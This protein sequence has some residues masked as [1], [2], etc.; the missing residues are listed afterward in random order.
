MK[1]LIGI[2][3]FIGCYTNIAAQEY[4][5]YRERFD[6]GYCTATAICIQDTSFYTF[7][8]I[9]DTISPYN[10]GLILLQYDFD[11]ILKNLQYAHDESSRTFFSANPVMLT[12]SF[13]IVNGQIK[14]D[15]LDR[16]PL[17]LKI[18]LNGNVIW[19]KFYEHFTDRDYI[20]NRAM[21]YH[22]NQK[23]Y[24][25]NRLRYDGEQENMSVQVI[26]TSGNLIHN[27]FI[28]LDDWG[29][30]QCIQSW[31]NQLVLGGMRNIGTP[32]DIGH[33]T[34]YL[35]VGI[36]EEGNKLWE[37]T[38]SNP[39]NTLG[40]FDL[41]LSGNNNLVGVAAEGI[42]IIVNPTTSTIQNTKHIIFE[43][44]Q[45][46][47]IIWETKFSESSTPTGHNYFRTLHKCQDNSGYIAGGTIYATGPN[48]TGE[49]LGYL[50]KVSNSGDSLWTRKVLHYVDEGELDSLS[51]YTH[52]IYDI[53]ETPN[54]DI[55]I[56]GEA[57]ENDFYPQQAWIAQVDEYGCHVSGCHIL[58]ATRDLS[59][60]DFLWLIHP[61]PASS[62]VSIYLSEFDFEE[63][64]KLM[65]YSIDG[66]LLKVVDANFG[67]TTYNLPLQN[68]PNGQ[69][70]LCWKIDNSIEKS[71]QLLIQK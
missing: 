24:L 30:V 45:N 15:S 49:V 32:E 10:S 16:L 17:L 71:E 38:S 34:E 8:L 11:G 62:H 63:S 37:W 44:D 66:R 47:E 9:A 35:L 5:N 43:L 50:A 1:T 67:R 14:N 2:L 40:I 68:L 7:G 60:E 42:S 23:F 55:I 52:A 61:N 33:R 28:Q 31:G 58:D 46:R 19:E 48:Q 21:I 69:Y 26:D 12:D 22:S 56:V 4:F 36:D 27:K 57:F 39:E 70:L 13:F 3:V 20:L 6:R 53:D 29:R 25:A 59:A 64:S 65:L 51:P 54:G 41:V 18:D